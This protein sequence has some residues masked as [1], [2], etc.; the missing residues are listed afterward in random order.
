MKSNIVVEINKIK[1]IMNVNILNESVSPFTR[2][3]RKL[4]TDYGDDI[5]KVIEMGRG[6]TDDIL[7][8][9][10]NPNVTIT[11][12]VSEIILRN[13]KWDEL[14]RLL[15]TRI[16]GNNK[17]TEKIAKRIINQ[18][19]SFDELLPEVKQKFESEIPIFL[20]FPDELTTAF[21]NI[22]KNEVDNLT[23][24]VL[25]QSKFVG[26]LRHVGLDKLSHIIQILKDEKKSVEIL[27]KEISSIILEITQNKPDSKKQLAGKL[28]SWF[29]ASRKN[30]DELYNT[31]TDGL[32][33][34]LKIINKKLSERGLS[35][36]DIEKL[37]LQQKNIESEI[38]KIKSVISSDKEG[39]LLNSKLIN[40]IIKPNYVN[41]IE[42]TDS[43]LIDFI[44]KGLSSLPIK[45]GKIEGKYYLSPKF[46]PTVEWQR[47]INFV[48]AGSAQTL[49]DI[50]KRIVKSNPGQ[51]QKW[52][53]QTYI[54]AIAPNLVIPIITLISEFF[55]ERISDEVANLMNKYGFTTEPLEPE[56]TEISKLVAKRFTLEPFNNITTINPVDVIP[57]L[58]SYLPTI[59]KKLFIRDVQPSSNSLEQTVNT[60][61]DSLQNVL[62]TTSTTPATQ[63]Q[64]GSFE[65]F[66]AVYRNENARDLG[67]GRFQHSDGTIYKWDSTDQWYE[68]QS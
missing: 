52:I 46:K 33:S 19:S 51:N 22:L 28:M 26:T 30:L 48:V 24:L 2:L 25:R 41:L 61:N 49:T 50:L 3:I 40:D 1:K 23:P 38:G 44:K 34:E 21:Y 37:V 18:K 15:Y 47:I 6:V 56:W 31:L 65:H 39:T 43:G 59:F 64:L 12:D 32:D 55:Y 20:E 67:D 16:I 66:K 68:P 57:L 35:N 63:S 8:Q 29:R 58:N 13:I 60:V 5:Y 17:I 10:K 14:G 27:E 11:D 45:F 62:N 42:S 54:R 36:E 4:A 53:A 9:L 7:R